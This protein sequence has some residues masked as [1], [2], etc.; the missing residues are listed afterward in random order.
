MPLGTANDFA[1]G[2]GLPTDD[3]AECLR[4]AC[5]R[6]GRPTDVG[7]CNN[8]YFINVASAG[9]GA[10]ITATT[11]V[12]M[13]KKLGGLAYTIMGLAKAFNLT[14]YRCELRI[15]GQAA[16]ADEMLLMAVGNNHLAGGGFDVAPAAAVDDGLLDVVALLHRPKPD[17]A[18]VAREIKDPLNP[19]NEY[20]HYKQL[21]EFTIKAEEKLHCN[22]DGEPIHKKTL[23]F[24]IL[25]RHIKVAY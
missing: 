13:K 3:L 11:P 1:H 17:L 14:P 16:E 4:I 25:H 5:T 19:D 6:E 24:S 2:L 23:K 10:E 15:P 7:R 9:F 18:Q 12:D 21:P 8:R 22:L 20:L